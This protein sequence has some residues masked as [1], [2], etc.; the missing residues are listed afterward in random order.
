MAAILLA[1]PKLQPR[2]GP[3]KME[4]DSM[5]DVKG[6]PA[7]GHRPVIIWSEGVRLAGDVFFPKD[8]KDGEKLPAIVLCHGW[9][10]LKE[11]LNHVE[12][13]YAPH[14]A[15]EGYITLTFDYRGWGESDSR[16]VVSGDMPKPD[17]NG[18]VT[19]RAKA[20]RDLVAPFDQQ[21]D[22]DAAISF[23]EGEPGVDRDRI[24][25]WGS[26]FGGGHVVWRAAH[27]DRVKCIVSQVGG[28]DPAGGLT[29]A[30]KS[31][32]AQ[33]EEAGAAAD[34]ALKDGIVARMGDRAAALEDLMQEGKIAGFGGILA[35]MAGHEEDEEAVRLVA[36]QN[37]DREA[38]FP[39]LAKENRPLEP[40]HLTR[41]WR[42]RGLIDPAPQGVDV[43]PGLAGTPH[44]VQ[45]IDF[46]PASHAH[47]IKVPTLIID[48]EKEE[49]GRQG[50]LVYD[51][52]KDRV[53][54]EYHI[55]EGITHYEIYEGARQK[56]VDMEIA[57]FNRHLKGGE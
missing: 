24:G 30:F 15:A 14:F 27:D 25:L 33:Y 35:V 3:V 48:A 39:I 19:V 43:V 52:V 46:S 23:I 7:L 38:L 51:K 56:A 37:A 16:L 44:Q 4:E 2:K 31:F 49:Y 11:H 21:H 55:F 1:V 32:L 36:D 12:A 26:S 28:L 5:N 47:K 53:P 50:Q 34:P 41:I 20:V 57:W 22:I 54:S 42:A 6:F 8:R 10:G 45:F 9:G 40:I 13:G 29:T 18:E 17:E